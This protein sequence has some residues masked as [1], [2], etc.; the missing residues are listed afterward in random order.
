[1]S[2]IRTAVEAGWRG[3]YEGVGP[4]RIPVELYR[5]PREVMCPLCYS[6]G[7]ITD[8]RIC[9]GT[10]RDPVPFSEVWGIE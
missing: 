9:S 5:H 7:F 2:E 8:C 3:A 10:G 6:D 4:K 1:M